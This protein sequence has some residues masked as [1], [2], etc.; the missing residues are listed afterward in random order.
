[1]NININK[2]TVLIVLLA[3]LIFAPTSGIVFGVW[4]FAASLINW[5]F[6]ILLGLG[7]IAYKAVKSNTLREIIGNQKD[8][9]EVLW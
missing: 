7:F 8:E 3:L 6:V 5:G 9:E 1:M 2:R 4:G